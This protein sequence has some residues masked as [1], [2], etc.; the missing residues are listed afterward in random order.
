MENIIYRIG[1]A[2]FMELEEI[3]KVE[4]LPEEHEIILYFKNNKKV[5]VFVVFD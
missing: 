1:E 3:S 4:Y 5:S 2:V